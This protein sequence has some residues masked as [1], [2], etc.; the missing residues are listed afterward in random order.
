VVDAL[1]QK[2]S[3]HEAGSVHAIAAFRKLG[4][5]S[6][7]TETKKKIVDVLEMVAAQL[8]NTPA[9]YYRTLSQQLLA[10]IPATTKRSRQ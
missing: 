6:T 2:I 7:V 1:L 5:G 10:N 9:F 4:A 8:G 3:E